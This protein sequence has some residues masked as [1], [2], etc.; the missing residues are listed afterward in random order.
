MATKTQQFTVKAVSESRDGK[1]KFYNEVGRLF[2]RE[3]EKGV[4]GTLYLHHLPGSE[5]AVFPVEKKEDEA[6]ATE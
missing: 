3:T 2:V 1:R 6:P 4:S 5:Y